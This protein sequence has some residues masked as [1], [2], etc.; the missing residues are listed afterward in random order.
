MGCALA[1]GLSWRDDISVPEGDA[2]GRVWSYAT[3]HCVTPM[4]AALETL[5]KSSGWELSNA[6]FK[7][8][9]N[10]PGPHPDCATYN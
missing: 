8:R 1:L 7:N 4:T 5:M 9:R 6:G 2:A 3:R 10:T